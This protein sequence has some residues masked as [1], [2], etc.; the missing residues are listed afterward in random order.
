[1]L[2]SKQTNVEFCVADAL[3]APFAPMK[4]D[5]ILALNLIELV[6]PEA[7]LSS[8]H[9]LLKAHAFAIITD[10]YDFRDPQS[11]RIYDSHSF[12]SLVESSGF[13]IRDKNSKIE[14]F[15]PWILKMN[16]RTYLFYFVDYIKAQ[17][18][19]KHKY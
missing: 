9:W 2:D 10:P 1:M 13:E 15:I 4:F 11:N 14:S 3:N 7:L 18:L 5:I 17:K 8:I 19:S 6:R 16:D 12:R